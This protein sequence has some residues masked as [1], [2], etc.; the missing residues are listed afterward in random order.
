MAPS[1]LPVTVRVLSTSEPTPF[2]DITTA[3]RRKCSQQARLSGK[4][5]SLTA[6]RGPGNPVLP[7][8]VCQWLCGRRVSDIFCG[9]VWGNTWGASAV[10]YESTIEEN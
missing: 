2:A 6:A 10:I 7:S 5:V 1:P 3:Q 8:N 9:L 4:T